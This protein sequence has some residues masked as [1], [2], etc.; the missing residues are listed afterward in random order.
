MGEIVKRY[1]KN[2]IISPRDIPECEA[3][4]NCG[5]VKFEGKY[6]LLLSVIRKTSEALKEIFVAEGTDGI[7]FKVREKPFFTPAREGFWA[8]LEY[9]SCDPRITYLEGTYYITIPVHGPGYGVVGLL[10]KTKDFQRFERIEIIA[11]PDNRVPVLFPEKVSGE[12]VRLDRP[13]GVY[14][15][16]L[17][18]SFSRDL[19][20]WGKH[21]P[22]ITPDRRYWCNLKVGPA[23]PPIKT[24]EGWLL[25]YHA[26]SGLN[27]GPVVYYL[28]AA[29]LDLK[30]P[31]R[32]IGRTKGPILSPEE[33]YE[34][35]GKV[36]NV[37]FS[38][39]AI[40]EDNGEIKIYY[41][42]ADTYICLATTTV[43]NLIAA[44]RG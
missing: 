9:D 30:D 14:P 41:G 2:P 35:I 12:Y 26:V 21:R 29:L 27:V 18:L 39:G 40:T 4:Y 25:I 8:S 36:N 44:C 38:C 10:G 34:R 22:L 6:L 42:A 11:L 15:G 19:I 37:V 24:K 23:G 32:I 5:A 1:E 16:S 28:G 31:L 33:P 20:Y 17:W 43:D 7:H 13:F 3:V